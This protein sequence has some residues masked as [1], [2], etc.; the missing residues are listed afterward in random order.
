MTVKLSAVDSYGEQILTENNTYLWDL[1]EINFDSNES[2]PTLNESTSKV[3]FSEGG[4]YQIKLKFN[5]T[6]VEPKTIIL[7]HIAVSS[8]LSIPIPVL[9]L[10]DENNNITKLGIT[11]DFLP[12]HEIITDN[13]LIWKFN[14]DK[15]IDLSQ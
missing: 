8:D 11:L 3:K 7:N 13:D 1:G 15:Y 6:D 9:N 10:Y 14:V 2:P 12:D 5:G 4:I